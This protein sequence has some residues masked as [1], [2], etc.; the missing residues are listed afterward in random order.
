M[1]RTKLVA[2]AGC[3]SAAVANQTQ[4]AIML[5]IKHVT[6][7]GSM[8]TV[9]VNLFTN[10]PGGVVSAFQGTLAPGAVAFQVQGNMLQQLAGGAVSTPTTDLN[11]L[12]DE[13]RDSQFLFQNADVLA[14][15][16]PFETAN[17]AGATYTYLV[18]HRAQSKDVWQLVV[19]GGAVV[20]YSFNAA[21]A[22]GMSSR[23]QAFS[24]SFIVFPEPGAAAM[25]CLGM[26]ALAAYRRR[27]TAG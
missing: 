8:H 19:N 15:T 14:V 11:A 25:G 13:S 5:Q 3:L 4:A 26:L 20:N 22:I 27:L 17:T 1:N 18:A 2:L 23:E 10:T 12:I 16:A 9:V 6:T 21:E 7:V 24:G